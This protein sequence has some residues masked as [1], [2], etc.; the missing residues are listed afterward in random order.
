M[1]SFIAI[2]NI[3]FTN[4]FFGFPLEMHQKIDAPN[5]SDTPPFLAPPLRGSGNLR[6]QAKRVP[7]GDF[8]LR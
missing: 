4:F 7:W 5:P 3:P 1:R 6:A 2:H 8:L